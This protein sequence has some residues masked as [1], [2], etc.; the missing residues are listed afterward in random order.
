M[1]TTTGMDEY[2]WV[3]EQ[4]DGEAQQPDAAEDDPSRQSEDP[5]QADAQGD[6]YKGKSK[7]KGGEDGCFNCGSKWHMAHGE[8]L[9]T[10]SSTTWRSTWKRKRIW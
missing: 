1:G 4:L 6:Y 5:Q 10:S 3:E 9:S 7:G 8:G 2:G